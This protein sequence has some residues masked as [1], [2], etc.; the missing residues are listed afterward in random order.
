[1]TDRTERRSAEVLRGPDRE[2]QE[3]IAKEAQL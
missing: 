3:G 2:S 1:M